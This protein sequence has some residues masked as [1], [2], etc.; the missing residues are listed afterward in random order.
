MMPTCTCGTFPAARAQIPPRVLVIDDEALV[1]WSLTTALQL[2]GFDAHS[3]AN[4][5]E[6]R[7]LARQTPPDIVL[8]DAGLWNTDPWQLVEEI[9]RLSPQCRFLILAVE[10]QAAARPPWDS[11]TVIRKPFD[12]HSVV[13]LMLRC[14]RAKRMAG[15]PRSQ[16]R[17]RHKGPG[18]VV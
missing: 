2:T 17:P 18:R 15:R 12:V 8:L 5:S 16:Q 11:C 9:R 3:A 14:S 6:A 10:G 13:R 4:A 1:C 7:L